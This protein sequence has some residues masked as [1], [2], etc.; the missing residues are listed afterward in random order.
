MGIGVLFFEGGPM[1]ALYM[2]FLDGDDIVV[3]EEL[4]N[5]LF[6]LSCG[7]QEGLPQ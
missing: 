7:F 3:V 5:G 1:F 4:F 2:S 6:W